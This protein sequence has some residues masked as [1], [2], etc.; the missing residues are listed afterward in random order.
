MSGGY[1]LP[2]RDGAG[3]GWMGSVSG[4]EEKAGC[5]PANMSIMLLFVSY[6]L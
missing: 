3:I 2:V 4:M 1:V 5:L 6:H